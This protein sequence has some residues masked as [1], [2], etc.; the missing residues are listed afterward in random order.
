M[1]KLVAIV[2]GIFLS[3]S[4]TSAFAGGSDTGEISR[5]SINEAGFVHLWNV[6]QVWDSSLGD[7]SCSNTVAI[8]FDGLT[9]AGQQMHEA[10]RAAMMA[11]RTVKVWT[12][13]CFAG[14]PKVVRI[15]ILSN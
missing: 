15:D 8:A 2:F 3:V 13:G 12:S 5:T 9:T 11:G 10:A 14:Y 1:N 7:S 4:A 6:P